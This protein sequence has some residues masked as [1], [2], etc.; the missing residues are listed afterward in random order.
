M[1]DTI[2]EGK[3]NKKPVATEKGVHSQ[4]RDLN[5]SNL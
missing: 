1:Q 5:T 2:F 4:V 3:N